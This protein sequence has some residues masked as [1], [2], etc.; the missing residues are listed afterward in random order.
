MAIG[1]GCKVHL[2]AEELPPG[3]L[4]VQVSKHVT[5]VI[6]GVIYD[7]HDCSRGGTRCVYGLWRKEA[8]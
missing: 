3:R 5:A 8:L 2:R 6:D 1:Q 4:V 7:T